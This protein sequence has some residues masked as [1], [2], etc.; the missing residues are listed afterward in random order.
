VSNETAQGLRP[1]APASQGAAAEFERLYRANVDA[2]TAFFARRSAD[3]QAVAD[4]TADTFAA[5][6][7]I[8]ASPRG[9]LIG[10]VGVI[11]GKCGRYFASMPA[12]IAVKGTP[13][14]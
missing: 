3:P 4:L 7:S 14:V 9:Y 1:R 8:M 12:R 11:E 10:G 2:V 13:D 6:V 5:A